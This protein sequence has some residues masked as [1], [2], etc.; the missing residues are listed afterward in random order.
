MDG[1]CLLF[2]CRILINRTRLKPSFHQTRQNSP[3]SHSVRE[4]E[5]DGGEGGDGWWLCRRDTEEWG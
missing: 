4:V 5:I 3:F 2:W 1:D